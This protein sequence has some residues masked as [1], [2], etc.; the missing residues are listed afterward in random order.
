MEENLLIDKIDAERKDPVDITEEMR[1]RLSTND[2]DIG[3][4]IENTVKLLVAFAGSLKKGDNGTCKEGIHSMVFFKIMIDI[5]QLPGTPIGFCFT[6]FK[7]YFY[8]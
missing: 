3:E 4:D 2:V 5:Y 7:I 8:V 6:T 1:R